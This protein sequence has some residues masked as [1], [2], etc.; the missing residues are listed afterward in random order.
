MLKGHF[1]ELA[2]HFVV[3]SQVI[4][5]SFWMSRVFFFLAQTK[6]CVKISQKREAQTDRTMQ[7]CQ[8]YFLQF[9]FHANPKKKLAT[10]RGHDMTPTLTN[11]KSLKHYHHRFALF[12]PPPKK[13]HVMISDTNLP[14]FPP[15]DLRTHLPPLL[16]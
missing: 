8:V 9:L 1:V 11:G 14:K 12:Y 3:F 15:R 2:N 16:L 5:L 10:H 7:N 4:Q 13:C 6:S